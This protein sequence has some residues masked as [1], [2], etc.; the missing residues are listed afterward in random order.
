MKKKIVKM[1]LELDD[2]CRNRDW[3]F[4]VTWQKVNNYSVEIYRGNGIT[5]QKIIYMESLTLKKVLKKA[6]NFI[7]EYEQQ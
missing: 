1:L 3:N 6:M 7:K 4:S 5:Y 2:F